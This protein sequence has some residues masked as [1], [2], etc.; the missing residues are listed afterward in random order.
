[1]HALTCTRVTPHALCATEGERERGA[2]V[3]MHCITDTV[4]SMIC[5]R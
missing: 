4:S 1:M 2:G 3:C 5:Q